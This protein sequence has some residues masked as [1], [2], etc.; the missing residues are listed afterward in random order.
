MQKLMKVKMK[1]LFVKTRDT[2]A[3]KRGGIRKTIGAQT[4]HDKSKMQEVTKQ[5]AKEARYRWFLKHYS[6]LAKRLSIK[7]MAL[8]LGSTPNYLS[9][10]RN[11]I[12]KK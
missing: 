3:R 10:I 11:K 5:G 9:S 6:S 12:V 2:I 8:F 1:K 4:M 7:D